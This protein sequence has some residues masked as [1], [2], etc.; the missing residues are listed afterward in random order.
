MIAPARPGVGHLFTM[1]RI[2]LNQITFAIY[3]T[4]TVKYHRCPHRIFRSRHES[5]A[6]KVHKQT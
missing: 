5:Q 6:T 3:K 1:T 2:K 4:T